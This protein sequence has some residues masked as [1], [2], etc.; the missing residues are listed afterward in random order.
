[1]QKY[2]V[3][4]EYKTPLTDEVHNEEARRADPCLER[5]GVTWLTSYLATDRTRMICEFEAD[6]AEHIRDALRSAD[7]P[8]ARVWPAIK[9][10]R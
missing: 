10:Q 8:F 9:Y 1:M 5:Y 2:V 4:H 7:V 3:E 6:S